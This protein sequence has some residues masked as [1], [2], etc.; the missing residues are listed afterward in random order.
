[1]NFDKDNWKEIDINIDNLWMIG[2]RAKGGKHSNVYH[3]NFQY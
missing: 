3:G 1:M 2:P